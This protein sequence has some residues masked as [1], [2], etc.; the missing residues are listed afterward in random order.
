MFQPLTIITSSSVSD[1]AAVLISEK[2]NS[3][4]KRGKRVCVKPLL[5]RRKNLR[6]YQTLLA[7]L[8]LEDE[9]DYNI[10]FVNVF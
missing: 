2:N 5:K 8:R 7:K 9:Y 3:R 10:L 6:I 1:V 4:E